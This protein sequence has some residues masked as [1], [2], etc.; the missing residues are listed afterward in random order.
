[1]KNI[2]ARFLLVSDSHGQLGLVDDLAVRTQSDAVIHAGDFG[3]YDNGSY[4]RLSDRELRLLIVHSSLPR[5]ERDRLLSLERDARVDTARKAGLAGE[6]QSYLDGERILRVPMY[7]VW[8]NHEDKD[9]VERLFR[10]DIQVKNL[11]VL[12]HRQ[13]YRVGPA[14]VYGLGGNLLPGSKMLQRPIAGGGGKVWSTLS[15]YADLVKTVDDVKNDASPRLFVSHVSP[16]K[17]PFV[18]LMGART[19]ADFTISGHMGAP[20][21]MVWN[22]FAI[23]SVEESVQRLQDGLEAVKKASSNADGPDSGQG[24]QMLSFIQ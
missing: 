2:R 3:F 10:G 7:A 23:Y 15:Q 9:V 11:H 5:Q 4:E 17:E 20:H 14:L 22:P 8:G 6:F 16:G 24:D 13:V 21:C 12:H 18:E 1:M 19:R